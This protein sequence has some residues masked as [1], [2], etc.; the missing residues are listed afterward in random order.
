M[1]GIIDIG[2]YIPRYRLTGEMLAAQW[3]GSA[4]GS[5]SAAN[6]DEDPISMAWEAANNC[7]GPDA[8]ENI[9]GLYMA[10]TTLPYTE[11]NNAALLATVLNLRRD[12]FCADFAGSLRTGISAL[13]AARDAVA[14]GN[15]S[16]VVIAAAEMRMGRPSE[17]AERNLADAA[18][19][20]VVGEGEVPAEIIDMKSTVREYI[21]V[22]RTSEDKFL[23]SADAKFIQDTGYS[24]LQAEAAQ[25]ILNANGL[26][27]EDIKAVVAYAPDARS[28]KPIARSIKIDIE[29]FVG[30]VSDVGD[31]G[32][33]A[34]FLGLAKALED[35][36]P[37]D[38]ILVLSHSSGADAILLK[39]TEHI[40]NWKPAN[41]VERQV[42]AGAPVPSYGKYLQFR[43]VLPGEELNVWT[44]PAVLWREEKD[45]L[46]RI[47]KKCN[48]CGAVQFPVRRICWNCK[49]KDDMTDYRLGET[50]AVYTFTK[51]HLPPNPN[52]PTIM[53]SV[54]LDDGGRFYTQLTDCDP[55]KVEVGMKVQFTLRKFH[56][57][58]GFHNYFWKFRPVEVEK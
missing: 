41:S 45:N 27:P 10:S 37:G 50:G 49:A 28:I 40:K 56:S 57:G 18:A 51:D 12:I 42:A 15:A 19:A 5:R 39:V 54:D 26:G 31:A 36:A 7:L 24:V 25:A 1:I 32:G 44:S 46:R 43:G 48:K 20:V 13:R 47:A 55:N 33:V 52:P 3:G 21:D 30:L 6:Y 4:R 14:S 9:D 34:P 22:W 11:K 17:P 8:G 2:I 23:K 38:F 35:A 29:K 58:G 53:V 16:R